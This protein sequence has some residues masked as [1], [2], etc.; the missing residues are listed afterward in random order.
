MVKIGVR[1]SA[2]ER[3]EELRTPSSPDPIGCFARTKPP[4]LP[5]AAS[6]SVSAPEGGVKNNVSRKPSNAH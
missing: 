5:V 6:K 2:V 3:S 1:W 4:R